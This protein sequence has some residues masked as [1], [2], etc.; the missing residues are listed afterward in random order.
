MT[1]APLLA[2]EYWFERLARGDFAYSAPVADAP[3]PPI[4]ANAVFSEAWNATFADAL[5]AEY[6]RRGVLLGDIAA[7]HCERGGSCLECGH[8]WPCATYRWATT[9]REVAR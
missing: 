1:D 7:I 2:A 6:H 5:L 8:R 4:V 3:P 9:T